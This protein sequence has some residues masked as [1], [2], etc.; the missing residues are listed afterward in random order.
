MNKTVIE[1]NIHNLRLHLMYLKNF[2]LEKKYE[3][4]PINKE[5]IPIIT[6]MDSSNF[7]LLFNSLS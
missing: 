1:N 4:N 2:S 3:T 5:I 6:F 7:D